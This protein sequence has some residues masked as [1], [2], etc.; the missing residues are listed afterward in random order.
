MVSTDP[1]LRRFQSHC[2]KGSA[3]RGWE[4]GGADRW[5]LQAG[6]EAAGLAVGTDTSSRVVGVWGAGCAGSVRAGSTD[7][8]VSCSQGSGRVQ[9]WLSPPQCVIQ[10]A[11]MLLFKVLLL[12]ADAAA[13]F[14]HI[15][16][17][18]LS[19]LH[20]GESAL[21]VSCPCSHLCW[22]ARAPGVSVARKQGAGWLGAECS[23]NRPP[24]SPRPG[25]THTTHF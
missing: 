5:A 1:Q 2:W 16:A 9:A 24:R 14:L 22:V 7:L 15:G 23:V 3:G 11:P 8:S 18:V 12:W 6:G 4:Q 17:L 21:V 13:G 25:H 20:G 19:G 10:S